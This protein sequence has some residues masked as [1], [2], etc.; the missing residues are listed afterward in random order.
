MI[1]NIGNVKIV[2][3]WFG[4]KKRVLSKQLIYIYTLI[5]EIRKIAIQELERRTAQVQLYFQYILYC[6]PSISPPPAPSSLPP[7]QFSSKIS[8]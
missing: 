5:L 1:W 2:L 6:K 7:S 3:V 4:I 8:I